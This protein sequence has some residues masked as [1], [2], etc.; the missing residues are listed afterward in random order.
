MRRFDIMR[1]AGRLVAVVLLLCFL[2][3]ACTQ[4]NADPARAGNRS[5]ARD[6]RASKR[7]MRDDGAPKV[8]EFAPN[9]KLESLDGTREVELVEFRG[10]R[11][12]VLFFGSY[13]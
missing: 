7:M 13:T 3:S 8:G 6:G 11:P 1:S 9:F 5:L 10:D 2:P 4:P 12:V